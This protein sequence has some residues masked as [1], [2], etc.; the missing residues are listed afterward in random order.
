MYCFGGFSAFIWFTVL[1]KLGPTDPEMAEICWFQPVSWLVIT[2]FASYVMHHWFV[3]K[4]DFWP[5][6]SPWDLT[7]EF[8]WIVW[9][10]Y[11]ILNT[12]DSNYLVCS[13]YNSFVSPQK[14]IDFCHF[15]G[16]KWLKIETGIFSQLFEIPFDTQFIAYRV[17]TPI[18]LS[19]EII[20]F[21]RAH[22]VGPC[23]LTGLY[24]IRGVIRS[25]DLLV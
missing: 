12:H 2:Q 17:H 19:S 9:F 23:L 21:Y 20:R 8:D 10:A 4:I 7:V 15:S 25:L 5:N 16:R 18:R 11:I 22:S 13:V 3:T 24:L 1:A 14:I 6:L